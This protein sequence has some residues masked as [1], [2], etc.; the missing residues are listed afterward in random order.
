MPL[1]GGGITR[2]QAMGAAEFGLRLIQVVVK[3]DGNRSKDRMRFCEIII[4]RKCL[5]GVFLGPRVV[6]FGVIEEVGS[7]YTAGNCDSGVTQ[8]KCQVKPHSL[9]VE[10]HGFP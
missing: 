1:V 2:V 9:L 10:F 5:N 7:D 6:N 3:A 8:S 4:E